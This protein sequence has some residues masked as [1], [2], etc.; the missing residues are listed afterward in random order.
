MDDLKN[1]IAK[2][3]VQ[4]RTNAGFTQLQ[5]AEMLNYSDK[6]VSK[7]ERAEAIPDLRVLIQIA[8]I[9]N[10]TLDELVSEQTEKPLKPKMNIK[11]K[12]AFICMLSVGLT[13]FIAAVIFTA[14]YFIPACESYAGCVFAVA[15][16][17]SAIILTVFSAMWGNRKTTAAACSAIVWTLVILIHVFMWKFAAADKVYLFYIV[18]A[19][20]QVLIILWFA[21]RRVK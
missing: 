18:A 14:L 10:V 16:F 20:F 17:V 4:L 12:H 6:A 1:I 9:Y 21:F 5:L 2:N 3:L 15:P 19:F 8:K 11:K 7:W 13:F